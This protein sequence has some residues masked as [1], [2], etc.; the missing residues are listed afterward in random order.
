MMAFG[1]GLF[2]SCCVEAGTL[3]A[4][5]FSFLRRNQ[6]FVFL[7]NRG[8]LLAFG[9]AL[10]F[11]LH[12]LSE[13]LSFSAAFLGFASTLAGAGL[14]D[15]W[16]YL[17]LGSSLASP[18]A[19]VTFLLAMAP[20]KLGEAAAAA[21]A[22]IIGSPTAS[23]LARSTRTTCFFVCLLVFEHA[24]HFDCLRSIT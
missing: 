11:C 22:A 5:G 16:A 17:L 2:L 6:I 4:L 20:E 23:P 8:R 19:V 10:P 13:D 18:S 9:P 3:L 24:F 15:N 12:F 1:F 21:A 14:A 7:L